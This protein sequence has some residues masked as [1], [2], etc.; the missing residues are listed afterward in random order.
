[1]GWD[2]S[3]GFGCGKRLCMCD[4]NITQKTCFWSMF[5]HGNMAGE[6]VKRGW[7]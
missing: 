7:W 3:D 1:M 2:G 6:G 5:G 4:I